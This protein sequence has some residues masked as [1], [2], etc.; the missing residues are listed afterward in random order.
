MRTTL[1]A[2]AMVACAAET[3]PD[4]PTSGDLRVLTYNVQGL[5]DT[6][7]ESDRPG[8]DRMR[9]IAPGL[10][11][12]DVVALQEDFDAGNHALLTE[13]THPER[14][15]FSARVSPE[16]AYGAGLAILA[17]PAQAD[18]GELFYEAC[19]GVL[20]GASDCL[21]SKGLQ[22][23]T[24]TLGSQQLDIWNTHHE[25]GSGPDDI[26]A[27]EAQVAQVVAAIDA[28]ADHAALFL[29]DMNL[30]P[31][32]AADAAALAV[33]ADA[34]LRHA[35]YEVDCAEPDHIDQIYVRDAPSRTPEQAS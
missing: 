15:W 14:A 25:A 27:R 35:C 2:L 21:A 24:L 5:P 26:A 4:S 31:S 13:T 12:Y 22:R 16:R 10:E 32:R 20:D 9:A 30:R 23:M 7:T 18:Y 19:S 6:L 28:R 8:A 33:Y 17:R 34:G 1:L 3:P 11:A 29:G